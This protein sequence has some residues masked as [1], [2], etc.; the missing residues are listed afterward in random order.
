[1]PLLPKRVANITKINKK[2]KYKGYQIYVNWEEGEN[3]H[4]SSTGYEVPNDLFKNMTNTGRLEFDGD[5]AKSDSDLIF[6][7]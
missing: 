6:Y 1:M 5:I 2:A 4:V 7:E 3:Y